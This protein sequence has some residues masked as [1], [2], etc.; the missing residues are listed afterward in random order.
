MIKKTESI[1]Q[2][3]SEELFKSQEITKRLSQQPT[4]LDWVQKGYTTRPIDQ[5]DCAS[6]WAMATVAAVESR[7]A[8]ATGKLKRFSAQEL[9][10]CSYEYTGQDRG[11]CHAR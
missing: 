6:C 9:L 1:D 3:C 7:Y 4:N 8:I 10:D 11:T 2:H 5:G